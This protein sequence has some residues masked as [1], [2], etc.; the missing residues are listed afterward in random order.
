M[1][2]VNQKEPGNLKMLSGP[3]GRVQGP[4]GA[5][6]V[7]DSR[8]KSFL[9]GK[10]GREPQFTEQGV[11]RLIAMVKR[12]SR[13]TQTP[14]YGID[15]DRSG[16]LRPRLRPSRRQE[17]QVSKSRNSHSNRINRLDNLV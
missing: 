15:S 9:V 1:A 3:T 11:A 16:T 12:P 7:I 14:N 10:Y 6:I 2:A 13:C 4:C 8:D 17:V 5:I